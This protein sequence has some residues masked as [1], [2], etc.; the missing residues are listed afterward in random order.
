[1]VEALSRVNFRKNG[2]RNGCK[3]PQGR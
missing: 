3:N 1:V 2:C